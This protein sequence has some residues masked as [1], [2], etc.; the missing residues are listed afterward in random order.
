MRILHV[1]KDYAPV[2]GGIEN[3]IKTLAEAQAERGHAVSVLVTSLDGTSHVETINGV[4]V[5]YAARLATIASTPISLALPSLLRRETADVVHLHFPYPWGEV[6]NLVA[7][8]GRRVVLTYHSDIVRQRYLGALYVPLMQRVLARADS[9]IVTSPNYVASSAV[10]SRWQEKCVV[11][12][13]GIDPQRFAMTSGAAA[14]LRTRLLGSSSVVAL[15]VGKLRHYK[16]LHFLLDALAK[17]PELKLVVVGSGPMEEEWK[18]YVGSAGVA[19]RVSF[20]GEVADA[21]L[22]AYYAATDVVVLPSTHRSEAF[23]TVQLEAMAAGKPVVCTELGTGT[24]FVN[25][26][27]VTG[28]VVAPRDAAALAAALKRLL[29]DSALRA[30]MGAAGQARVA[31]QFG[32]GKMTDRVLATYEQAPQEHSAG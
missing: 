30:R 15:F 26:D 25:V 28:S 29:D 5:I 14:A 24:T 21:E 10:L 13:L 2:H 12:P 9:I 6:A 23:G 16:G 27:G 8:R 3:H 32:V 18:R 19:A 4:R 22:P 20:V 31:E 1:Y 17:L 7:G 11:V